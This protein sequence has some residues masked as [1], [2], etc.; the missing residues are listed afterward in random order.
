METWVEEKG[1]EKLKDRLPKKF[2]WRIQIARRKNTKGK[3]RGGMLL[4]V[5]KELV[6]EEEEVD[7][8][9]VR[10]SCRIRIEGES[11]RII[12][13]YVNK[14]I[15]RKLEGLKG[16][17]EIDEEE[18]RTIIGGDFN[19]RTGEERRWGKVEEQEEEE[20]GRRSKDKRVNKEGRGLINC[21]EKRG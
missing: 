13:I 6:I 20:K 8:E 19:A 1:W 7:K 11:W 9:E 12:G 3:A 10:M 5:K 2:N 18:V 15:E 21:I 17:M 16:W 4:W 14:D